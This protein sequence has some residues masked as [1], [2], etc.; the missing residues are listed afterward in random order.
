MKIIGTK[1]QELSGKGTK[2][3][4]R[5]ETLRMNDCDRYES[6]D[7]HEYRSGDQITVNVDG[8]WLTTRVECRHGRYYLVGTSVDLYD[9]M[10]VKRYENMDHPE[11][12]AQTAK[13]IDCN[14]DDGQR[15]TQVITLSA[16]KGGTGKTTTAIALAQAGQA[17]GRKCLLIDLDPQSNASMY[18]DADLTRPSAF[19]LIQG[20]DPDD[21]IQSTASGVDVVVANPDLSTLT[22]KTGSGNRLRSAISQIKDRYDYIFIDT[23]P[24]AGELQYNALRASTGLII[25]LEADPGS[26]QG[27]YQVADIV[28]E[29]K[30]SAPDLDVIGVIVTRYDKR[31]KISQQ[32][33]QILQET[34]EAEGI[35]YLTEIRRGVAVTETQAIR[36]SLYS[37]Q[38]K[39]SNPSKDYMTLF[40]MIDNTEV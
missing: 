25:P 21:V 35:P 31:P 24:T 39:R 12:T 33:R 38:Y 2:M 1:Y 9:G 11:K 14:T 3:T 37:S 23:P 10:Q 26:I 7:G 5:I 22:T 4:E 19:D 40:E 34:A 32:L 8:D 27:F 28:S 29:I 16:I 6:T 13:L 17:S 15:E 20:M 30:Q 36:G 18:L